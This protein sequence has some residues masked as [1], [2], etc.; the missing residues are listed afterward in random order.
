MSPVE[1]SG[2]DSNGEIQGQSPASISDNSSSVHIVTEVV[3]WNLESIPEQ[4]IEEESRKSTTALQETN[5][6][7]LAYNPMHL[8]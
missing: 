6:K 1:N 2:N 7:S 4:N 8:I 3:N 5:Q